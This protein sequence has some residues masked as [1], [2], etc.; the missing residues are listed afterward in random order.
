MSARR[1]GARGVSLIEA[2]VALAVMAFGMLGLAGLQ[3]TLRFNADVAKQ[4]SEAVRLAQEAI[5]DARAYSVIEAAAGKTAYADLVSSGPAAVAAFNVTNT[6]YTRTITVTEYENYKT[7]VVDIAWTDRANTNQTVRLMTTVNRAAPELVAGLMIPGTGSAVAL[8]GGRHRGIPRAAV[9][10]GN[11]TSTFTPPGAPLG[12]TWIFNNATGAVTFNAVA[13]QLL[14]GFVRYSLG[15]AQPTEA[16]AE[17]PTGVPFVVGVSIAQTHP[18]LAPN[19]GCFVEPVLE[20][21]PA[22]EIAY[23]YFCFVEIDVGTKSWSGRSELTGLAIAA[24]VADAD[25]AKF[26]VCRYTPY[27]NNDPVGTV[28]PPSPAITNDDHPYNYANVGT[29]LIDQNFLV[30]LAGD[31]VTPFDC[32]ADDAATPNVNGNSFHHQPAPP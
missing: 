1:R 25:A 3:T 13:G 29:P 22:V 15:P 6:V 27:R 7:V 18:A 20:G 4:R 2:L 24:T 10:Q 32:P 19:T 17:N 26:R 8:P 30:I 23:Q 14:T 31:G 11:G 5:E 21:A 16:D 12:T 9:D 28:N